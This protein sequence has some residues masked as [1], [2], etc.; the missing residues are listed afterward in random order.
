M[1]RADKNL[2]ELATATEFRGEITLV[3]AG[4]SP[5]E[6]PSDEVLREEIALHV[7][8]GLSKRDAASAVAVQHGL[9]KRDVYQLSI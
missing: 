7:A 4:A 3:V 9:S 2:A 5:A 6:R 1:P 8:A